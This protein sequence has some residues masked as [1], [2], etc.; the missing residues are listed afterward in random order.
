VTSS[1]IRPIKPSPSTSSTFTNFFKRHSGDK[2]LGELLTSELFTAY[3][4]EEFLLTREGELIV[5]LDH[6]QA[7][8]FGFHNI[9]P[10]EKIYTTPD[11][12]SYYLFT[13]FIKPTQSLLEKLTFAQKKE[14]L[15]FVGQ[16]VS[17]DLV[18]YSY[19]EA[20]KL[21]RLDKQLANDLLRAAVATLSAL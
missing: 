2:G 1:P 12:I 3:F 16:A 4:N 8:I 5:L 17:A 15:Q 20:M 10:Y 11:A 18:E 6:M 19:H 21:N 14:L 9:Y 13:Y 7:I